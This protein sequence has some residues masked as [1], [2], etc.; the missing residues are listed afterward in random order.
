MLSEGGSRAER[1]C[2][3]AYYKSNGKIPVA[4]L[5]TPDFDA[6]SE[7]DWDSLT[8]GVTGDEDSLSYHAGVPQCAAE[9]VEP[10]DGL[11]DLVCQFHQ[12]DTGFACGDTVGILKGELEDMTEFQGSDSVVIVPCP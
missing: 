4:I 9:D 11:D 3:A 8:F 5:S 12:K 2:R 6:P 7:V 1:A 10:E